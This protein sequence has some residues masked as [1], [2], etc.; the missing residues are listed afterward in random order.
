MLMLLMKLIVAVMILVV[1]IIV[2]AK[3]SDIFGLN[4][5]RE[6]ARH[7]FVLLNLAID[8][9]IK[10]QDTM[11]YVWGFKYFIPDGYYLL[12]YDSSQTQGI[13]L[14]YALIPDPSK[15]ETALSG[16]ITQPAPIQC[17]TDP[18]LCLYDKQPEADKPNNHIVQCKT[19]SKALMFTSHITPV[20]MKRDN[21]PDKLYLAAAP[22][23]E[24][25][26]DT[27]A[28]NQRLP[29]EIG[30]EHYA[31]IGGG[32]DQRTYTVYIEKTERKGKTFVHIRDG[33][34]GEWNLAMKQSYTK[35]PDD[36][37]ILCK[38]MTY[39]TILPQ[40]PTTPGVH[41]CMYNPAEK[42]CLSTVLEECTPEMTKLCV[43]GNMVNEEG[44]CVPASASP[45]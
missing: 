10:D 38:G 8:Q 4:D 28:A 44:K 29:L 12:G 18:C 21:A 23:P 15:S 45:P 19:Y 34:W 35:C 17:G 40:D 33:Q 30:V 36:S 37:A 16:I 20:R 1:I 24:R 32:K 41:V 3:F 11:S 9:V 5:E 14:A 7:N 22:H 43:C 26:Y 27:S 25:L 42:K 13:E 6:S 2:G 39:D 31:V